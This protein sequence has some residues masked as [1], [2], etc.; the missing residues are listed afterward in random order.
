[1]TS[2]S[3]LLLAEQVLLGAG[4]DPHLHALEQVDLGQLGDR[5]LDPGPLGPEAGLQRDEGLGGPE[6]VGRDEHAFDDLVRV[7]PHEGPV[8]ERPRLA[9]GRVAHDVAIAGPAVADRCATWWPSGTRPRRDRAGR[10]GRAGRASAPG[11]AS[12]PA[13]GPRP[14]RSRTT[15]RA[16]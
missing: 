5:L 8:L 3:A 9:L 2:S 11:R 12:G 16:R 14:H 15:H 6:R 10:T 13:R 4:D 1:M 7:G